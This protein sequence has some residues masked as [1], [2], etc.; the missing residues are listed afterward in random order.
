M[1]LTAFACLRFFKNDRGET[2]VERGIGRHQPSS[3]RAALIRFLA[4]LGGVQV[5]LLL[6]Y[7]GPMLMWQ[8]V[9]AGPWPKEIQERSYLTDHL[10]GAGSE[11]ACPGPGIPIPRP[12]SPYL[13]PSG[14]L[15]VP[16]GVSLPTAVPYIDTPT[17]SGPNQTGG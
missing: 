13:D 14:K 8:S 3:A 2:V 16:P 9:H 12:G 1:V 5:I 11:Q 6:T 4:I 17:G 7:H 10:C 15:I